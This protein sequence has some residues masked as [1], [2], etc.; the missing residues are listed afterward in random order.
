MTEWWLLLG[1]MNEQD[2]SAQRH[3]CGWSGSATEEA[4]PRVKQGM[5]HQKCATDRY[6]MPAISTRP[7]LY[8]S[9]RL[10][11]A[12]PQGRFDSSRPLGSTSR[13]R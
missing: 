2:P 13:N 5:E 8:W 12:I 3:A 10:T 7:A 4:D 1:S 6:S 9:W 11:Q